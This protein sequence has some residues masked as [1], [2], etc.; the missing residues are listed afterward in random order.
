M[1]D[2]TK[3]VL[4]SVFIIILVAGIAFGIY[5]AVKNYDKVEQGLSGNNLYT[6]EDLENA[7]KE[8]Y[9]EG[10][11]SL[12]TLESQIEDLKS[13]LENKI[14]EVNNLNS[15]IADL[16]NEIERL[17]N[18]K[19]NSNNEINNLNTQ[20]NDLNNEIANLNTQIDSL[21]TQIDSLNA[22][23]EEY[24][25]LLD[26]YSEYVNRTYVIT[27]YNKDESVLKSVV[28]D[29]NI[30]FDTSLL[31]TA[32]DLEGFV[33]DGW[34]SSANSSDI[35]SF[36]NLVVNSN[37]KFY[38]VYKEIF[39]IN[40]VYNDSNTTTHSVLENDLFTLPV[41]VNSHNGYLFKGWVLVEDSNFIVNSENS[42]LYSNNQV[43]VNSN[44]TFVAVYGLPSGVYETYRNS[45][46]IGMNVS[47][48][49]FSAF[50]ISDKSSFINLYYGEDFVYSGN[51][52]LTYNSENKFGVDYYAVYFVS[53]TADIRFKNGQFILD[54]TPTVPGDSGYW[55]EY[56]FTK[57]SN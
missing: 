15:Q 50:D 1:S 7:K 54:M 53:G 33:F 3:K 5:W 39:N 31:P 25:V 10:I 12:K 27:F 42:M 47:D 57:I 20:I 45:L 28:V 13:K 41:E 36:D 14:N 19:V 8:G 35:I 17:E 23:I 30:T 37:M 32:P 56:I 22:Q 21:N 46:I 52:S 18:E 34:S 16:N 51:Y 11:S 43:S 26:A 48:I 38:A 44:M 40:L 4:L 24:V 2:T 6:A 49:Y 55:G 9:E 29:K